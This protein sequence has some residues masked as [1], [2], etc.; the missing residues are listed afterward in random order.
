MSRA[1]VFQV[2]A[3]LLSIVAVAMAGLAVSRGRTDRANLEWARGAL[4]DKD[5][6]LAACDATTSEL[7]QRVYVVEAVLLSGRGNHEQP[8]SKP[9][10][11]SGGAERT[12][13]VT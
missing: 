4:A 11:P 3:M 8:E 2:I 13:R 5:A 10:P 7:K 12:D 1:A 6:K 9:E